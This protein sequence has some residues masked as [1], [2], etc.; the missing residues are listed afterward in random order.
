MIAVAVAGA[1][2]RMGRLTRDAVMSQSDMAFAGGFARTADAALDVTADLDALLARAPDVIVD[3]TVR[4]AT[5]RIA[6]AALERNI[7]AIV[8]SSEWNDDERRELGAICDRT[9]TPAL[10]VPNFA[11]GAVLMMR[12]AAEASR[13]FPSAEIVE[14]HRAGKRDMPS[15]TAAATAA[16]MRAQAQMQVPIHSVRLNGLLSHQEVLFGNTGELL[17]IRHDSL[18][19][20][21][22]VAGI[23]LA[24]RGIRTLHGLQTGL[25]VLL[26]GAARG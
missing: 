15:G 6:Q 25:D 14:L 7:P 21:S 19:S 22:F 13:W 20:D 1:L 23:L 24:I 8:G 2:G 16:R 12:F 3:F 4:P 18:A 10:I 9:G 5:Q 26:D 17:T 11:I